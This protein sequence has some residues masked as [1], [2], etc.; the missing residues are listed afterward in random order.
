MPT[1]SADEEDAEIAYDSEEAAE[2][3]KRANDSADNF[4]EV[5][6]H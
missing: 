1:D 5:M 6:A 4:C 2:D 3:D